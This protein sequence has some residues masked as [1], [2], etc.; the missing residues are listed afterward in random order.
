M[1]LESKDQS[2]VPEMKLNSLNLE[3]IDLSVEKFAQTTNNQFIT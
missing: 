3:K 2:I 1:N